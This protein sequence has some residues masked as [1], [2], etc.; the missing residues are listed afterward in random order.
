[1]S[2]K[3]LVTFLKRYFLESPEEARPEKAHPDEVADLLRPLLIPYQGKKGERIRALPYDAANEIAVDAA[4]EKWA[5]SAAPKL[6]ELPPLAQRVFAERLR[7]SLIIIQTSASTG[8]QLLVPPRS[9]PPHHRRV[10]AA[11][12]WLHQMELPYPVEVRSAH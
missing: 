5:Q 4:L 10:A 2:V 1:M 11:L 8:E 6:P 9:L 12:L 7:Q 3:L